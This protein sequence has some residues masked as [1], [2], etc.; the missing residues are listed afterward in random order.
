MWIDV[1]TVEMAGKYEVQLNTVTNR[2][3]HRQLYGEY[4]GEWL[5]GEPQAMK[6]LYGEENYLK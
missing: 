4:V 5:H 2:T 3:R 6:E 1:T